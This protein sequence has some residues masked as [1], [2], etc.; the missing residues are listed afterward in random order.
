M[1]IHVYVK[2]HIILL[3]SLIF[4]LLDVDT[5]VKIKALMERR[6]SS[7]PKGVPFEV[8]SLLVIERLCE[9]FIIL[10]DAYP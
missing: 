5:N 6:A 1:G 10:G 8:S 7:V 9:T 3:F 2:H 4:F